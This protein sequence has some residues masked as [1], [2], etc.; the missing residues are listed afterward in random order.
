MKKLLALSVLLA[1]S[2]FG[3][4]N[5]NQ[6]D[7]DELKT[8]PRIGKVKA[9]AIVD[10]R[11]EHGL[12][13]KVEDIKQVKGISDSIFNAIVDDITIKN[14]KET[15]SSTKELNRADKSK[16]KKAKSTSDKK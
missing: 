13:K 12:F 1:T 9:Q 6:A 15:K 2:V 3:A 8:L 14:K 4:V 7:V 10:Y 11:K 5:I 16:K